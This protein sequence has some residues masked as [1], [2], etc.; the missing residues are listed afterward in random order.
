M[1]WTILG[2][3][4][5]IKISWPTT[6]K[7]FFLLYRD[8]LP[9]RV[10]STKWRV[11]LAKGVPVVVLIPYYN[12]PANCQLF[13]PS[14]GEEAPRV[15][16]AMPNQKR[17]NLVAPWF[18][19]QMN[20]IELRCSNVNGKALYDKFRWV[21]SNLTK[22]FIF[23][24]RLASKIICQLGFEPKTCGPIRLFPDW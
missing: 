12:F 20:Q 18:A 11:R 22:I 6:I 5:K 9:E 17:P 14:S 16:Q 4:F 2:T 3:P 21:R 7:V 10:F 24:I 15:P 1:K 23:W 19:N 8:V 13:W